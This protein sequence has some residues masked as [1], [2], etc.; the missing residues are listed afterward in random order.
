MKPMIRVL[1]VEPLERPRVVMF[2][3]TLKNLQKLVGGY[4]QVTYP[5]DDNVG[6]I[7]NEDGISMGLPLNRYIQKDMVIFGNFI[8]CGLSDDDFTSLTDEQIKMYDHLFLYPEIFMKDKDGRVLCYK[9][10]SNEEPFP[11]F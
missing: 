10:G 1:L 6:L 9:Y 3:P 7:C 8:I 5:F 4:I 11:V 2:E